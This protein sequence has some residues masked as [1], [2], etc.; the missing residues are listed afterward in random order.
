MRAPGTS[1]TLLVVLSCLGLM[2]GTASGVVI[3]SSR[4]SDVLVTTGVVGQWHKKMQSRRFPLP[5]VSPSLPSSPCQSNFAQEGVLGW[6]NGFISVPS[7]WPVWPCWPGSDASCG[8]TLVC[9]CLATHSMGPSL[10]G[11][12]CGEVTDRST[13][14]AHLGTT[15]TQPRAHLQQKKKRWRTQ[16]LHVG[17]VCGR[18]SG[19]AE[20]MFF[21]FSR[22]PF[23]A[24]LLFPARDCRQAPV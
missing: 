19:C 11:T 6:V 22:D 1:T 14:R 2:L 16:K 5:H 21:P 18:H 8:K 7:S 23:E 4:V 13:P 12:W 15:G 10:I 9:P 20:P 17:D 3:D 24:T